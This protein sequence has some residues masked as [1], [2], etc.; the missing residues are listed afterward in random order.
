[1]TPEDQTRE[2]LGAYVLDAVDDVERRRVENLLA[3]DPSARDEV[4]RL[5]RVADK[6][7]NAAEASTNH[8]W[9]QPQCSQFL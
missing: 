3:I 6:L 5:R 8:S 9:L 4:E 2:L 7:G 1:M